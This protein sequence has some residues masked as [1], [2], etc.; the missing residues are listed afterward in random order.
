MIAGQGLDIGSPLTIGLGKPDPSQM[1]GVKVTDPVTKNVYY[2]PGLGGNGTGSASNL[3]GI[4]DIWFINSTGPSKVTNVQYNGRMDFQAT[5]NDLIA[6]NIYYTPVDT[7]N[8]NGARPA[9]LFHHSAINEAM[10]ALWT[11][12]VSATMINELR[13]N[14]A[15]WRW[16]ELSSNPQI[17]LGL[18]QTAYIGDPNNGNNIGTANPGGNSPG[19]P[20]GIF[21]QWTYSAKDVVSKVYNSHTIKFG[22]EGTIL[23]FVQDAPWSARPNWGFNNYWDFLNDAP[24]SENGT[25]NPQNGVPT[26]VRKDSR[27]TLYGFFVQDTYKFRPNLTLTGGLRWDYFAPVSFTRGQLSKVVLGPNTQQLTALRMKTGGNLYSSQLGNFGPQL[28]FAWSPTSF[29]GHEFNNRLVIRGG[30]G[31]GYTAPEQAITLNGWPNIP[32]TDNGTFLTGTNVVYDFPSDPH[33]FEPYPANPNTIVQFDANNIPTSGSPVSVTAFPQ[34]FKTTLTYRYSL[35]GQYDLGHNLVATIGYQGS[36][37]RHLTRQSNLNLIYGAAG[38]ALNPHINNVDYYSYDAD[39]KYNAL[40]TELQHR[41]ARSFELDV[42]YRLSRSEDNASGPYQ[43]NYYQWNPKYDWGPSDFDSTHALKIWGVY[44]PTFF[45]SSGSWMHKV[46]DG[47]SLS[48]IFNW[49]S[50]FPWSPVYNSTCNLVYANGAC[51]NGGN[52]QLAPAA[53]LGGAGSN[54]GNDNFL[55]AGGNFPNGGTTYFSAAAFTTCTLPFPQVCPGA[56][57][58]PGI[59]RNSQRGPRYR[60]I[61]ATISKSFGLP[62]LPI[63]G[64]NARFEFRA[65]AYNLFNNLNLTSMDTVVTDKTFGQ[66]TGALAGRTVE[67]QARFSF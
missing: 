27:Q 50:G 57:Q 26:D 65:N 52:Q 8:Y 21:D 14:A 42:Q 2:L 54:F 51:T 31:I 34:D 4:A 64:E 55:R 19:G 1:S 47:W 67:M 9:N 5:N 56:P 37:S 24:N 40:L 7:T 48:G 49:H 58:H 33:Q 66:A 45:H 30:F 36:T 22:G 39:S 62:K 44:S 63:M 17:P 10:T 16:N 35:E 61:D 38:Y 41:F 3:D 20:A 43:I 23:H 13:V 59:E 53:Y 28:G 29:R 15:G 6:Y 25:F 11:H 32:F 60:D 18:P 12:T 46:I